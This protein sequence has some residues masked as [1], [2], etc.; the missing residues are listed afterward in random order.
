MEG[1]E[2]KNKINFSHR[3]KKLAGQSSAILERVEDFVLNKET[4]EK[5]K[6]FLAKDT[7]K[8][9]G[10]HYELRNG[11]YIIMHMRGNKGV[12]FTTIRQAKPWYY[13]KDFD[14]RKWATDRIGQTFDI[15]IKEQNNEN[16]AT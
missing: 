14:R 3:Y 10:T 4:R 1:R 2:V 12:A 11:T 6:D 15:V 16:S 9:D 13:G 8:E 5:Y 7:E